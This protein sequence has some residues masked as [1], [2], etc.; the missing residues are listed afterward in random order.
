MSINSFKSASK[1]LREKNM[2]I[3]TDVLT[4]KERIKKRIFTKKIVVI[5]HNIDEWDLKLDEEEEEEE[6]DTINDSN[7][8][9]LS[10]EELLKEL[11]SL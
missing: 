8:D 2:I 3:I 7:C 9:L 11:E 5:N 10:D 1:G 4:K 6:E